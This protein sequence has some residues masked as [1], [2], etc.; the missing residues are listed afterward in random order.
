MRWTEDDVARVQAVVDALS[1]RV[2][3]SEGCLVSTLRRLLRAEGIRL[4][5]SD[6][7][8]LAST[9]EQTRGRVHVADV[10]RSEPLAPA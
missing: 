4:D 10:L 7:R 5:P 6:L 2:T 3:S 9:L 1:D 8:V